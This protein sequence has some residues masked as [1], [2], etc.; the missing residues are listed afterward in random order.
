MADFTIDLTIEI[1]NL[2]GIADTQFIRSS[3]LEAKGTKTDR[4]L[5]ILNGLEAK[6]Y[7]TGPSARDYLEE[8][9]LINSGISIEY[10]VYD[11]PA[12]DQLYPPYDPF[13]TILDLLFMTGT[14]APEYIW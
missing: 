4:L 2:L 6:H 9:K 1:S 14:N 5:C 7:I 3:N 10:M 13:V 12:Y 8:E 11:Y